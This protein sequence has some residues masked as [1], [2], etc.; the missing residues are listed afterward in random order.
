MIIIQA[1]L[2]SKRLPGK[3]LKKIYGK[4]ILLYLLENLKKV[5]ENI[6]VATSKFDHEIIR[7]CKKNEIEC[8]A[9]NLN[10]V[11]KRFFEL[12]NKYEDSYFVR[13]CADSPLIDYRL[14]NKMLKIFKK[15]KMN[16]L[17]NRYQNFPSG[18]TVEILDVK[19]FKTK[20]KYF[21]K[22]SH[23]EHVTSYFYEKE[24]KKIKFYKTNKDFTNYKMSI[25]T[26][27]DYLKISKLIKIFQIKDINLSSN[28]L[29]NKLKILK[30]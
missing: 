23:F 19:Y 24:R 8:F 20:Y 27:E 25:D 29:I 5:N 30:I 11:A 3:V 18:Q 7:F 4:P 22:Q 26:K 15:E 6:I 28:K 12:C 10:N 16:F 13:L 14:V 17:S 9:S 2:N 21:K 1:R